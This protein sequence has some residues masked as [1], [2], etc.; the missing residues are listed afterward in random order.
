[1]WVWCLLT[2]IG[3]FALGFLAAIFVMIKAQRKVKEQPKLGM[4]W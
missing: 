3:C 2:G 4:L 1:M